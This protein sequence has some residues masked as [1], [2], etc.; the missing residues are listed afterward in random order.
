MSHEPQDALDVTLGQVAE[1]ESLA[2]KVLEQVEGIEGKALVIQRQELP[3]PKPTPPVK[4]GANRRAHEFNNIN[5]FIDY[6]NKYGEEKQVVVLADPKNEQIKASLNE[7][8]DQ[9]PETLTYRPRR[10]T[11]FEY[12][13]S[14]IDKPLGVKEFCKVLRRVRNYVKKPHGKLVAS[15]YGQLSVAKKVEDFSSLGSRGTFGRVVKI[16][17]RGNDGQS[18]ELPE[19]LTLEIKPYMDSATHIDIEVFIDL[20]MEE[21]KAVFRFD[22]PDCARAFDLAMEKSIPLLNTGLK[23]REALVAL[24]ALCREP[25]EYLK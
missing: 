2:L 23:D 13:L 7:I 24:G 21:D 6:L 25:W 15:I 22:A 8:C 12:L 9:E 20:D 17:A 18:V 1:G 11:D 3:A 10:T 19:F 14:R 16:S 5:H 4:S